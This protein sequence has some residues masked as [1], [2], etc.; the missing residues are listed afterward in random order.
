VEF[1]SAFQV[2][3]GV[4]SVIMPDGETNVAAPG[5]AACDSALF[6]PKNTKTKIVRIYRLSLAYLIYKRFIV[7]TLL[8]R[9]QNTLKLLQYPMAIGFMRTKVL[10]A[11]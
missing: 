4:M 1:D 2:Y 3:A 9:N 10:L 6:K 8:P 11:E 7:L 5:T